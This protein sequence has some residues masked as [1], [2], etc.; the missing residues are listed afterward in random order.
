MAKVA[1]VHI[2]QINLI[3]HAKVFKLSEPFDVEGEPCSHALVWITPADAFQNAQVG[4]LPATEWGSVMGGH[5][6][7]RAG[8]IARDCYNPDDAEYVNGCYVTALDML[9]YKYVTPEDFPTE[10][11]SASGVEGDG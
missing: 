11:P 3:G 4:V 6:R 7:R 5:L 10:E 1:T 8:F 2:D 9:G